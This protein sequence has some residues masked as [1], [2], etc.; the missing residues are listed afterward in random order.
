V[1]LGLNQVIIHLWDRPDR[2][3]CTLRPASPTSSDPSFP[4]DH[5]TFGFAIA[6]TS[7]SAPDGSA[8]RPSS[9]RPPSLLRVYT[10]EH[11]VSDVVRAR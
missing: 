3:R 9:W 2:S 4:S 5:A 6:M 7:S 1:A 8:C 10:G 11:Y